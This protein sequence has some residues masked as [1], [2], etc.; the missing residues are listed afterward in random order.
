MSK[1]KDPRVKR[2]ERLFEELRCAIE[3]AITVGAGSGASRGHTRD[4]AARRLG[5]SL[6]NLEYK[7]SNGE[8]KAK[9]WG[10]RIVITEAEIGRVLKCLPGS[11][12]H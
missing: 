4:Q 2:I 5:I 1:N 12:P 3:D 8:I 11:G 6:R 7:I 10:R 9:K